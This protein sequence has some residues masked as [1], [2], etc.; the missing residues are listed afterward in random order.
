MDELILVYDIGTTSLKCAVFDVH[1]K[2]RYTASASYE[3]IYSGNGRAEQNATDYWE[4][5]IAST[6]QLLEDSS[7]NPSQIQV[8]GLS[9][10]MNGCLP[11][12]AEGRPLHNELIHSDTRSHLECN[13]IRALS[14]HQELY[15][16]TGNRV[17][18]HFGLPK[19]LWI[20][21]KLPDVYKKTAFFVNS[22]DYLRFKLTSILGETDA[23]DA[24]LVCAMDLRRGTWASDFIAELDLDIGKFPRIRESCVV[25]GGL[26]PEASAALGLAP[27]IPVVIGAGDGS[28]ATRGAGTMDEKTSYACLG[29]SAWI[30]TLSPH[31]VMDQK[32][33]MQNFYDL[34][35]KKCNVCG[36]VQ[37]AGIAV[38]WAMGLVNANKDFKAMEERISQIRCGADGVLFAPYLMGERTPYWDA[39]ARGSFI[40]F[41]LGHSDAHLMR[42]VYEGVAFALK[43][44]LNSYLELGFN[45]T[46]LTLIGGGAKSQLWRSIFR[47]VLAIPTRL[48]GSPTNAT[49]LGAAMAAAVGIGMY[50]NVDAATCMAIRTEY[51]ELDQDQVNQY[52]KIYP[53]YGTLYG[54]LKSVFSGLHTLGSME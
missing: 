25:S 36:T 26:C 39:E 23:S 30:S 42:A 45:L 4:A 37:S 43:D 1:G 21:N 7:L 28:C 32:M 33:R 31:P 16:L 13:Q 20:K 49:S 47:N 8:I 51:E 9:G 27:G 34:D 41:S 44:V 19:I 6:K 22:K 2:E 14:P 50:P 5:A 52:S 40:G 48:H 38:D 29:S 24:S 54:S 11:L 18:E 46:E 15:E 3:T 17:D 53:V 12:D 10:H 35:G